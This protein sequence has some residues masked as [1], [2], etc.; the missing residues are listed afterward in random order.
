MNYEII[1]T[2]ASVIVLISFTF[3]HQKHIRMVNILGALLFV[4]YGLYINAFS[5]WFLN[6]ALILI[7]VYKLIKS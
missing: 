2:I 6:S 7:H 3:K 5:I 4:V 1:G